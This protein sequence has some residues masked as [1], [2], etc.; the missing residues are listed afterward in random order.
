MATILEDSGVQTY[1]ENT[2][3]K[4]MVRFNENKSVARFSAPTEGEYPLDIPVELVLG[5]SSYS[6]LK[7]V[8]KILKVISDKPS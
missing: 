8:M 5:L 6:D 4:L 7:P 1:Q 3:R 2:Y